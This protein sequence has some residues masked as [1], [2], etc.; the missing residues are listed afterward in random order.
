[1]LATISGQHCKIVVFCE[2]TFGA[3]CFAVSP[4]MLDACAAY[5]KI[6]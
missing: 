1:M 6:F 4:F 3:V 2:A 5:Y